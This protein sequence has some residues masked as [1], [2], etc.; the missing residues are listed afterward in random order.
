[1]AKINPQER[2]RLIIFLSLFTIFCLGFGFFY[3]RYNLKAPFEEFLEGRTVSLEKERLEELASLKSTDSDGD[4]LWDYDELYQYNTSP[5]LADSDSDGYD[6]KQEIES[7]ND[8]NCLAG[9]VCEQERTENA[10]LSPEEQ[11]VQELLTKENV[12]A[13]E[14]RDILI[15]TGAS[16]AMLA[17]IDDATLEKL[18]AE[19]VEETGVST[20][21]LTDQSA[22]EQYADLLEADEIDENTFTDLTNLTPA[23]IRELLIASGVDEATL[24]DVDDETLQAIYLEA[25]AEQQFT[26][27]GQSTNINTNII[28]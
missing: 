7:G 3:I 18:F 1:M 10:S 21:D 20:E 19:T 23:E 8:P 9:Q 6:D 12:T 27:G 28:E 25:L 13:D 16:E 17:D 22:E 24:N 5:Y 14:I 11:E 26:S 15:S 4:G 2:K